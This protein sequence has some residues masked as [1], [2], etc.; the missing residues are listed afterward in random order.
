M[1]QLDEEYCILKVLDIQED[2]I[3]ESL[4]YVV[5]TSPMYIDQ[6]EYL[7]EDI[8]SADVRNKIGESNL[9]GEDDLQALSEIEQLCNKYDCSY[10]R[11]I[12]G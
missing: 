3:P 9:L 1:I 5:K 6:N 10:F 12:T 8:Y 11:F 7:K 4:L 2:Q